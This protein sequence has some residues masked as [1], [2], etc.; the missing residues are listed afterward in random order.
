MNTYG[1][2]ELFMVHFFQKQDELSER[3]SATNHSLKEA[4]TCQS[5]CV[6]HVLL[7]KYSQ[8]TTAYK[9]NNYFSSFLLNTHSVVFQS[10]NIQHNYEPVSFFTTVIKNELKKKASYQQGGES[11]QTMLVTH[12]LCKPV[13]L[14]GIEMVCIHYALNTSVLCTRI[15]VCFERPLKPRSSSDCH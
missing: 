10:L 1:E 9:E 12:R 8:C 3:Q 7:L 5:H 4:N 6:T 2:N 15:S 14:T 11:A 13:I